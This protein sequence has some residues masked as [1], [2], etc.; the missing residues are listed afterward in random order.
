M[1]HFLFRGNDMEYIDDERYQYD[2]YQNVN[3]AADIRG[4]TSL[5]Q[6]EPF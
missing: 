5:G 3:K 6:Q 1:I 2:H 4:I